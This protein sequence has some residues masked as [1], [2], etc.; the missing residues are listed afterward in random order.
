MDRVTCGT[1][2][3]LKDNAILNNQLASKLKND[4]ALANKPILVDSSNLE[5][6]QMN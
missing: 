4:L 3:V 1:L 2:G 5:T 6:F